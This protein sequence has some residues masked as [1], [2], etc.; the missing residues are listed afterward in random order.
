MAPGCVSCV[1]PE[2][3]NPCTPYFDFS[4]K[5]Y[6]VEPVEMRRTDT[7]RKYVTDH[8]VEVTE[9]STARV[10]DGK[11][12]EGKSEYAISKIQ[13]QQNARIEDPLQNFVAYESD[14]IYYESKYSDNCMNSEGVVRILRLDGPVLSESTAYEK[15]SRYYDRTTH[16][17]NQGGWSGRGYTYGDVVHSFSDIK[18][19]KLFTN[20]DPGSCS[21]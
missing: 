4:K 16:W 17:Q 9:T 14:N 5:E 2:L 3:C 18:T 10:F 1:E 12:K 11:K 7:K 8:Y 6:V 20:S 21:S 13:S 19:T 15:L